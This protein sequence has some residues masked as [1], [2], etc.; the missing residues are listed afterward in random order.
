MIRSCFPEILLGGDQ[1]RGRFLSER[2]H[3]E[4]DPEFSRD[5]LTAQTEFTS[6]SIREEHP[7]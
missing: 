1:I 6:P 7:I 4:Q 2:L 5:Y 3:H